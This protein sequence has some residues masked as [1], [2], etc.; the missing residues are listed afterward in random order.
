MN[1]TISDA[2]MVTQ[3]GKFST[4]NNYTI[5]T[6]K[7]SGGDIPDGKGSF[8]D[9]II[10][11]ENFQVKEVSVKLHNMVHTWVGD[12]VVSLRHGETGIVVDLFQQ[13]GK[14]NFSSSGYSSDIKGDY[15]FNDHNSEDFEAAAGANTVVPSGNYHPVESLSAF[16]GLSA[17]GSWQLIIKD[18]AAG[19]SGS[20]GSWSLD[21]GYTQS[22]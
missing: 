7:G 18:N 11:K 13:P 1:Q 17:A 2:A 21:L 3:Q 22:A 5:T 16:D 8:L 14:P 6:F 9:N 10:V 19:D 20:L 12:L 4:T 15:S